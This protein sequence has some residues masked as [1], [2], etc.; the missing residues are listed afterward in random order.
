M[1]TT[2]S[3]AIDMVALELGRQDSKPA[4]VSYMNQTIRDVHVT[5]YA[6]GQS[7]PLKFGANLIENVLT[8]NLDDNY[9][10]PIPNMT[11]HQ[12]LVAVY[13]PDIGKYAHPTGAGTKLLE[14]GENLD[15]GLNVYRSGDNYV[16]SGYG[17]TGSQIQ[18]AY[19]E[20]PRRLKYYASNA[21]PAAPAV[22]NEDTETWTYNAPYNTGIP[23]DEEIAR[24]LCT[25]WLLMRWQDLIMQGTRAKMYGRLADNDK[26]RVAYSSF[27]ASRPG[28]AAVESNEF[29]GFYTGGR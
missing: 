25:N 2:F 10:W 23:A 9:V 19:Y 24:N 12:L 22:Y 7:T 27:E 20:Y 13:Y 8:A 11:R 14:N 16:F 21:N 1:A 17:A 18:V 4:L 29:L 3:Q 28:M 15:D 6:G 5:N 26:A